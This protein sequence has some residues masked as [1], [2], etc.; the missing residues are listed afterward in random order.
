MLPYHMTLYGCIYQAGGVRSYIS[1]GLSLWVQS[2]YLATKARYMVELGR[3][4]MLHNKSLLA[5]LTGL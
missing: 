5:W 3:K 1:M 2:C 4:G